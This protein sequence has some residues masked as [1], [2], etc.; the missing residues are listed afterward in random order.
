M[1]ET[2][3]ARRTGADSHS[4]RRKR[5]RMRRQQARSFLRPGGTPCFLCP[6]TIPHT[7]LEA[8]RGA[9]SRT[10]EMAMCGARKTTAPNETAAHCHRTRRRVIV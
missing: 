4:T 1:R 7:H 2:S 5:R 9:H 6:G 8:R 3:L 10:H